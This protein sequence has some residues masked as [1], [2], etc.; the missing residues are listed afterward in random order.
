MHA[1]DLLRVILS[2]SNLRIRFL[3]FL[4]QRGEMNLQTLMW[5]VSTVP[6][7][8]DCEMMDVSPLAHIERLEI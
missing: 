6:F 3:R 4:R 5:I 1:D 2:T 7:K 8:Y